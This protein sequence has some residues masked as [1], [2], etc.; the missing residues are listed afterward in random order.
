MSCLFG[1]RLR[2]YLFLDTRYQ[3]E[4]FIDQE[5]YN[6]VDSLISQN[7]SAFVN[8]APQFIQEVIWR[9]SYDR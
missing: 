2:I 7:A 4:I 6:V 1:Q 5:L 8:V 9:G 3:A